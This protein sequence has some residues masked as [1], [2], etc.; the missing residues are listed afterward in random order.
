MCVVIF[1]FTTIH[2]SG[3]PHSISLYLTAHHGFLFCAFCTSHETQ[4]QLLDRLLNIY[5]H[6]Q[7][8]IP[9][10][11]FDKH[12]IEPPSLTTA[13]KI[14][15]HKP[16]L[17]S[18]CAFSPATHSIIKLKDLILMDHCLEAGGW[19]CVQ[20]SLLFDFQPTKQTLL[21]LSSSIS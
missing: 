8:H 14:M 13:G 17:I 5:I 3:T 4:S 11:I 9:M 10:C 12:N 1:L 7:V 15:P 2:S 18:L 20:K 21:T 6:L 16:H 19:G